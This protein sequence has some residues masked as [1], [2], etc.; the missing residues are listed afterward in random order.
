MKHKFERFRKESERISKNWEKK[1]IILRSSF[2]A[3]KNEMF[4]R[5]T[6]FRQFAI[7]A[8]TSFNYTKAKPLYIQPKTNSLDFTSSPIDHF[9]SLDK[10]SANV[11]NDQASSSQIPA[12]R[13][14]L[15]LPLMKISSRDDA[16]PSNESAQNGSQTSWPE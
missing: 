11:T 16:T 7:L 14:P 12:F 15:K 3:L 10:K 6:L 1:F 9:S 8:D 13:Q 2:H 5:H 4:T